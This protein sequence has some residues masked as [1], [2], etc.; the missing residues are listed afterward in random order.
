M[1]ISDETNPE[2]QWQ[3]VMAGADSFYREA[4]A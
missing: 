1:S 2:N 3:T 4:S